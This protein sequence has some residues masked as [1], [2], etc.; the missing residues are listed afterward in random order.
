M[1]ITRVL[2]LQ[3]YLSGIDYHLASFTNKITTLGIHKKVQTH[4]QTEE[5]KF[6]LKC[7][8]E[9]ILG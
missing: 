6:K 9:H 1:L 3:H 7:E 2:Q 8:F 4:Y 5:I